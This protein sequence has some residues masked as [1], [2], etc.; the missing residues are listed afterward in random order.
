MLSINDSSFFLSITSLAL[1][2]PV[3]SVRNAILPSCVSSLQ[4]GIIL[5]QRR[6]YMDLLLFINSKEGSSYI[7]ARHAA[8]FYFMLFQSGQ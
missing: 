4:T 5:S 2:T 1:P 8:I 3:H 7:I 6:S